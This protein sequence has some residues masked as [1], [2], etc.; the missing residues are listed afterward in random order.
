MSTRVNIVHK[1]A[2]NQAQSQRNNA[3]KIEYLFMVATKQPVDKLCIEAYFACLDCFK[4]TK[5]L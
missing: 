2:D 4:Y 1:T 5:N 3:L